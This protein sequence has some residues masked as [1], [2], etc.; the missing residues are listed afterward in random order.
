MQHMHMHMH[1]HTHPT[2]HT[3]CRQEAHPADAQSQPLADPDAQHSMAAPAEASLA[4]QRWSK[5][6]AMY[7]PVGEPFNPSRCDVQPIDEA[8][9][10]AFIVTNHYSGTYPAARFRAGVF[11][12]EPFAP[13]RLVGVGVFSVPMNQRVVP[14]YFT[15]LEPNEGIELGRFALGD[16]LAANAESWA[17]ARMRRLLAQALPEVR[18]IVAYS[19]P[20][21]RRDEHG[22]LCK[23]GHIGC[24]YRASNAAYRGRSSPR[25]LWMARN[26]SVFADRMLSKLRGGEVGERYAY[27]RLAAN[28]APRSQIGEGGVAYLTRLQADGWLRPQRHPGNH[29]FTFA[30]PHMPPQR[31][32][33][34][35]NKEAAQQAAI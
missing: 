35:G 17:L 31:R 24:I 13:E 29:V 10:K 3:A 15:G 23:R 7:R 14:R 2:D 12:K 19:D 18:G 1:M 27:E 28:G 20:I 34:P 25:T 30:Q 11:L 4:C 16:E 6:R 32:P 33:R 26:G 5:R 22:N 21:E 9:A 8:Q